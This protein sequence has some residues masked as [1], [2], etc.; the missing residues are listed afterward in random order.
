MVVNPLS[1]VV[2]IRR[3]E[4]NTVSDGGIYLVDSPDFREDI[5]TVV[6]VGLGKVHKC[7]KCAGTNRIPMQVKVGDRVIFS[8][9]GHQI[10]K[11]NGDELVVTK[12]DS[13]IAVIE[14]EEKVSSARGL[15]QVQEFAIVGENFPK[16]QNASR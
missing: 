8:T 10:T 7:K 16:G 13:I 11:V 6:Y 9:N 15:Q 1:D 4:Q 14:D 2:I 3:Q 12:Q 5:G